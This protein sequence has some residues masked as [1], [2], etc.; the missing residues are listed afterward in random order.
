MNIETWCDP[1][2]DSKQNDRRG[3][4]ASLLVI[5]KELLILTKFHEPRNFAS[6]TT[7]LDKTGVVYVAE[8]LGITI[9]VHIR[10]LASGR[11]RVGPDGSPLRWAPSSGTPS[12]QT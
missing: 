2:K 5:E 10:S 6:H 11:A 12:I 4:E 9:P 1:R 7:T 3:M 8:P